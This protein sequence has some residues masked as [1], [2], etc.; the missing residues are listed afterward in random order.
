VAPVDGL[1]RRL[2]RY[3]SNKLGRHDGRCFQSYFPAPRNCEETW[4][5]ASH[6][7]IARLRRDIENVSRIHHRDPTVGERGG[8]ALSDTWANVLRPF[9][10]WLIWS[11]PNRHPTESYS[12][13]DA[14]GEARRLHPGSQNARGRRT[15]LQLCVYSSFKEDPYAPSPPIKMSGMS[16]PRVSPSE[17]ISKFGGL[18]IDRPFN[19]KQL[20]D[21]H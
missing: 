14:I 1:E 6:P 10:P 7:T 12:F 2:P 3:E 20:I 19:L 18:A 4:F 13:K 21:Y 8:R 17:R 16:R 9:P 11:A 15:I 5:F